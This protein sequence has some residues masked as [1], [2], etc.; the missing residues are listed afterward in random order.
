VVTVLPPRPLFSRLTSRR[1]PLPNFSVEATF[2]RGDTSE[3]GLEGSESRPSE[4]KDPKGLEPNS[5]T[6]SVGNLSF[7]LLTSGKSLFLEFP[8]RSKV[9]PSHNF[10]SAENDAASDVSHL[11]DLK[12]YHLDYVKLTP[13]QVSHFLQE[14]Q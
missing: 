12:R 9:M 14:K 13:S 6:G 4:S 11:A 5:V 10:Y 8:L 7:L 1:S 2:T 3:E